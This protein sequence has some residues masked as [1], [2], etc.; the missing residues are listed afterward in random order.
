[1][2]VWKII[3]LSKWV[4][5]K[6]HVNLPGCKLCGGVYLRFDCTLSVLEK[7]LNFKP[8]VKQANPPASWEPLKIGPFDATKKGNN[9]THSIHGTNGIF[10]YMKTI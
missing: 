6:F 5:F 1:M 4:I 8:S 10:P 7:K 3:F 9:L 2:E